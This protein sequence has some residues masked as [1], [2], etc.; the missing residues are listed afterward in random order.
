MLKRDV[1]LSMENVNENEG[2]V[3]MRAKKRDRERKKENRT[4][5]RNVANALNILQ[6]YW[7]RRRGE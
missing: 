4:L 5:Y 2:F 3:E 1:L 7:I 6:I